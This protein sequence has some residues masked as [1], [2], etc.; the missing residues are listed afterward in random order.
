MFT[1]VNATRNLSF[2]SSPNLEIVN[3]EIHPLKTRTDFNLNP[4]SSATDFPQFF[5][6]FPGQQM[7]Y[8]LWRNYLIKAMEMQFAQLM[9]SLIIIDF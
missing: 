9:N 7:R 5:K 2:L 3:H 8:T 6:H 4:P 1:S